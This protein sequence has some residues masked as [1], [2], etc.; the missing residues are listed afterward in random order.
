MWGPGDMDQ[1]H[2]DDERIAVSDLMD[3]AVAYLGLIE[4]YLC[5]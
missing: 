4:G 5:Q 1:W 2:S 3:G